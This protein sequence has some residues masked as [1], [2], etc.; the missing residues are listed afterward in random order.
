MDMYRL[1][2][3]GKWDE[4]AAL[5][6][7]MLPINAAVTSGFGIAGLKAGMDMLGYYGGPVRAPLMDLDEKKRQTLRAALVEGGIVR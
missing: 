4:A 3:R 2:D 5:Q 7:R 1:F 6:R